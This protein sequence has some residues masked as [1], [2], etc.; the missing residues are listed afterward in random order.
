MLNLDKKMNHSR[1]HLFS[2]KVSEGIYTRKSTTDAFTY[3]YER[4]QD[5]LVEA[6]HAALCLHMPPFLGARVVEVVSP[7]PLHHLLLWDL[8]L[9]GIYAGKLPEAERPAMQA[10]S[11]H[12]VTQ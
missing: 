3:L 9:G 12:H 11:K 2:S 5:E 6:S 1:I 7:K 4:F 10:G 8:E